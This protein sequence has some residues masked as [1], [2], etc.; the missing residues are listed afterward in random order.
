MSDRVT[1]AGVEINF[2]RMK[3]PSDLSEK[4]ADQI[5]AA[6]TEMTAVEAGEKVNA[7]E[8]RQVGH[9]WLRN[10]AIAPDA[11]R[12]DITTT[13]TA[14]AK[15]ANDVFRSRFQNI[16]W[17]GIGGSGLGPQLMFDSLRIPGKTPGCLLY[18]SDAADE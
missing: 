8:G 9:Y 15:F 3:L 12:S 10:P 7:D 18:T 14:I 6:V 16:L 2:Q 5:S 11:L 17:I 4:Y 1:A 13:Q